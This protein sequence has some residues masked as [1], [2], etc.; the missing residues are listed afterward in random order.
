MQL[1]RLCAAAKLTRL[2]LPCAAALVVGACTGT[3]EES[4]I[5]TGPSPSPPAQTQPAATPNAQPTQTASPAP[6]ATPTPVP[7]QSAEINDKLAKIFQGAVQFDPAQPASALVGDFNG[8]G[9][10]DIAVVVKPAADKLEDINSEVAN[11]IVEDPHQVVLPDPTKAKQVLPAPKGPV[12]VQSGDV[13]LTVIHGYKEAGWR[14]PEAQQT[15][16]LRNAVGR[17]LRVQP[18]RDAPAAYKTHFT[19][20]HGDILTEEVAR[21][22]GCLYW[23]GAKYAWLAAAKPKT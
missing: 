11:W 5:A 13:L 4:Q 17:D 2:A 3:R 10:E 15:Y 8:D 7:P 23:T 19:H 12:K 18:R 1:K 6:S 9:S 14:N 16:L 22:Y 21:A 20:L